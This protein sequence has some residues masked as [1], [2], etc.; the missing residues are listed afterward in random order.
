[1][2]NKTKVAG[3]WMSRDDTGEMS[4]GCQRKRGGKGKW[5]NSGGGRM[6]TYEKKRVAKG[7]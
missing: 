4:V 5:P 2:A 6:A 1:M 7:P 3:G